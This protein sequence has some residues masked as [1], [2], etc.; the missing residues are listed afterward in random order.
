MRKILARN[1]NYEVDSDGNI[2]SITRNQKLNPKINHDG[3]LRIQLWNG[4]HNEYVSLHIL[5]AETF[6]PKPISDEKLV[7]DHIDFDKANNH[8]S[9]LQWITQRDNIQRYWDSPYRREMLHTNCKPI[10]CRSIDGTLVEY[11]SII[12]AH[13]Q[14]KGTRASISRWLGSNKLNQ[15]GEMWYWK[16]L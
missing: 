14:G 5:I 11:P 3:Y 8:V 7:V 10:V 9:N 4:G 16:H 12:E 1:P 15:K 2:Y 13:R 6:I